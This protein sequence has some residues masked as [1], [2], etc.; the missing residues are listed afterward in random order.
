MKR[1]IFR[2][3]ILC[4]LALILLRFVDVYL[5]SERKTYEVL[6]K[7]RVFSFVVRNM[8]H[9]ENRDVED[10]SI[11]AL[12]RYGTDKE[13]AGVFESFIEKD[14]DLLS[15]EF[16]HLIANGYPGMLKY[17]I[18]HYDKIRINVKWW[19]A[20]SLK[21]YKTDPLYPQVLSMLK[22]EAEPFITKELPE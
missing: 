22:S 6:V 9:S 12:M 19:I 16:E 11:R 3:V 8:S 21:H 20:R 2:N 1:K 10:M 7:S 18:K 13:K 4:L 15:N 5:F 17:A 14:E